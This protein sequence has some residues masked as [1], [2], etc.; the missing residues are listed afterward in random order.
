[1]YFLI[2]FFSFPLSSA[3]ILSS[4]CSIYTL[5]FPLFSF[6]HPPLPLPLPQTSLSPQPQPHSL[7]HPSSLFLSP[8]RKQSGAQVMK[9]R[10]PA[11]PPLYRFIGGG[12]AREIGR[13]AENPTGETERRP[14]RSLGLPLRDPGDLSWTPNQLRGSPLH[15]RREMRTAREARG[16]EREDG[17]EKIGRDSRHRMRCRPRGM[18]RREGKSRH[19]EKRK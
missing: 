19:R 14:P 9:P 7:P 5:H 17:V 16:R 4:S 3:F 12:A 1:M 15:Q 10:H 11:A 8:N 13:E 2:T 18:Q 6:P